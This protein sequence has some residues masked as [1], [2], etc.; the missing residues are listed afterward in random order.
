MEKSNNSLISR[1]FGAGRTLF[2]PRLHSRRPDLSNNSGPVPR[3]QLHRCPCQPHWYN[4]KYFFTIFLIL[5][6]FPVLVIHIISLS[7]KIYPWLC[8]CL[9]VFNYHYDCV[10]NCKVFNRKV[11]ICEECKFESVQRSSIRLTI[12]RVKRLIMNLSLAL[13]NGACRDWLFMLM[14]RLV[15][16]HH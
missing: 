8:D 3:R 11:D 9:L 13:E 15:A 14:I 4:I 12:D 2:H 7:W 10:K 5:I 16:G 1:I 6:P